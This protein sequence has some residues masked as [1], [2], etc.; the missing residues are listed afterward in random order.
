MSPVSVCD[1][2]VFFQEEGDLFVGVQSYPLWYQHWPVLVT[3]QLYV[4]GSLQQLLGY[5]QQHLVQRSEF[6]LR[7]SKAGCG[8]KKNTVRGDQQL[9]LSS[10]LRS[11]LRYKLF[12][13]VSTSE[14]GVNR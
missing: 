10:N 5:L 7:R 6:R 4:V 13:K 14:N 2:G 9:H 12:I 1:V 8:E 11:E 3:A